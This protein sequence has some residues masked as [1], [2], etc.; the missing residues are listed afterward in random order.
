MKY[1]YLAWWSGGLTSAV[2]CKMA[3]K[4]GTINDITTDKV[5]IE[6]LN[7]VDGL[8]FMELGTDNKILATR[9][10]IIE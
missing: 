9:K 10:L 4:A 7:L 3:L 8:Y 5:E 6:R 1:K 2:A